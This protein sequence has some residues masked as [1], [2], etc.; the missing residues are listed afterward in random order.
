[1]HGKWTD[2]W[3]PLMILSWRGFS[4]SDSLPRAGR[5]QSVPECLPDFVTYLKSNE[6]PWQDI[7]P[8]VEHKQKTVLTSRRSSAKEDKRAEGW[9]GRW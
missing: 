8:H 4:P 2:G 1:V 3:C 5:R 9:V 7:S 6:A